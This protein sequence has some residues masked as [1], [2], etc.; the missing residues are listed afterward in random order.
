[1]SFDHICY[2]NPCLAQVIIRVDFLEFITS[3]TIFSENVLKVILTSFPI[4]GMRQIVKFNDVNVVINEVNATAQTTSQEG[5]QQEFL[6]SQNNKMK[7]SNKFVIL[8]INKY[9]SFE[10]TIQTFSPVLK[11]IIGIL[12]INS[13]RTGIRYINIIENGSIRLTK[14]LFSSTIS[15]LINNDLSQ[16]NNGISCVRSMCLNE[17]RVKDMR[18]N[19][20]YGMYNPEYPSLMKTPNFVLDFDCYCD[21]LLTGYDSIISHIVEG[22]DSIQYLFEGAITDNLRKIMENG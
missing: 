10:K 3:E 17:Y 5:F 4:A 1:M 7:V 21:L 15:H 8:E 22:H 19:F 14:N 20:R 18:L 2:K 6:D 12:P 13:V 9:E 11:S 16:D